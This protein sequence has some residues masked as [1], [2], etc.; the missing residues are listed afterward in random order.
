MAA[1]IDD[2]NF[3]KYLEHKI[4]LRSCKRHSHNVMTNFIPNPSNN[5]EK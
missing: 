3:P 4:T 5:V 1:F 2:V